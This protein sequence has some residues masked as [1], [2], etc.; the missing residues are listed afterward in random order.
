MALCARRSAANSIT[1]YEYRQLV[2]LPIS[3]VWLMAAHAPEVDTPRVWLELPARLRRRGPGS[4]AHLVGSQYAWI[5]ST[6]HPVVVTDAEGCTLAQ[7]AAFARLFA[8]S[9]AN[10]PSA[11]VEDLIIASRYRAAYRAARRRALIGRQSLAAGPT[12]EFIAI[13]PDGGEFAANLSFA[14]T[15]KD[16]PHW[17][18]GSET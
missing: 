4:E 8:I 5:A 2:G 17:P 11:P 7:N 12:S 1:D 10:L 3:A 13:H 16:P 6:P 15:S 14:R 18:P 9:D